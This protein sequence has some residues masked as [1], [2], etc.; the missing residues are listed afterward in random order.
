MPFCSNCGQQLTIGTEKFCPNCGQDLKGGGRIA[1]NDKIG[2]SFNIQGTGGDVIG[3]G[4][5]G[6]GNV[7]GKN[8]TGNISVSQATYNKLEPEFKNSLEEFLGLI[9]K[10][11]GQLTE[12]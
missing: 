2:D 3:V 7:I 9:N 10:K 4:V 5:R 6:S 1:T 8:I 12:E 11:S